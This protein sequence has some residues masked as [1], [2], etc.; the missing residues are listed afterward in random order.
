MMKIRIQVLL[1]ATYTNTLQHPPIVSLGDGMPQ[2]ARCS[3]CELLD[4][5]KS[6]GVSN[7]EINKAAREIEQKGQTVLESTTIIEADLK[8]ILEPPADLG[9]VLTDQTRQGKLS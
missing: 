3:T 4:Y 5:L 6:T 2:S 1:N 9:K 8:R 7:N